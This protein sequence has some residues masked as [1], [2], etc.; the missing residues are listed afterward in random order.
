MDSILYFVQ[1]Y[2]GNRKDRCKW[3]TTLERVRRFCEGTNFALP[4]N[5][6]KGVTEQKCGVAQTEENFQTYSSVPLTR[7]VRR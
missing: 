4:I 2:V 7:S 6:A 3:H 1:L 5:N